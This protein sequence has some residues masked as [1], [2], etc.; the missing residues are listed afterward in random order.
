MHQQHRR[1]ARPHEV[2]GLG[3]PEFRGRPEQIIEILIRERQ[4]VVGPCK[5]DDTADPIV[6]PSHLL[7]IFEV[8]CQQH[9]DLRAGRMTHQ[10]QPCGIH[11]PFLRMSARE[12]DRGCRIAHELWKPGLWIQRVV[13]DDCDIPACRQGRTDKAVVGPAA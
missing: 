5:P 4:K 3:T 12:C 8:Q 1:R 7:E 10:H 13:G 2:D 9:C 6:V 11:A